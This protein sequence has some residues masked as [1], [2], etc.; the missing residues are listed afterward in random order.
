MY[1][2][3]LFLQRLTLKHDLRF[4]QRD[5]TVDMICQDDGPS[6]TYSHRRSWRE[7]AANF[8]P[9]LIMYTL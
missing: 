5:I 7:N 6:H 3:R 8:Y 9:H 4:L 2:L 1:K